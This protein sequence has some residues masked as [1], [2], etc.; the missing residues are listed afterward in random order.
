MK[1]IAIILFTVLAFLSNAYGFPDAYPVDLLTLTYSGNRL[2]KVDDTVANITLPG[3]DDFKNYSNANQ[4]YFY[5][6]NGSVTKDMNKGISNIQYSLLNLPGMIDIKSPTGEA[7]N[8]YTYS[9]SGQK[10]KMVKK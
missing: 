7:R 1:K 9:A 8:E 10:L 3:S 2:L 6:A 4:E 5:N